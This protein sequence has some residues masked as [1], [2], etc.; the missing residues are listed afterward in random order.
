M[1]EG[2]REPSDDSLASS[3]I[4]MPNVQPPNHLSIRTD[5]LRVP[6]STAPGSSVTVFTNLRGNSDTGSEDGLS[7]SSSVSVVS[8]PFSEEEDEEWE[9]SRVQ[10]A[11]ARQNVEYVLLYDDDNTSE[12]D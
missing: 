5:V 8:V 6:G 1:V 9:A 2:T 11:E 7:D 3:S 10:E 4:I 12:E